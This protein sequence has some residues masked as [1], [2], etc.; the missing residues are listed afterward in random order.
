MQYSSQI[1]SSPNSDEPDIIYYDCTIRNFLNSTTPESNQLTYVDQRSGSIITKCS[2]YEFSIV[3]FHC[4]SF[5]LPVFF[6]SIQPNQS[7]PNLSIYSLTI[8][9]D[10]KT[11]SVTLGPYYIE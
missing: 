1:Q 7:D 9:Y 10:D 11:S 5:S 6:C 4:D 2:D 3:R 8:E